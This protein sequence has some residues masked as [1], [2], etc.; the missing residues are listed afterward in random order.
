MRFVWEN[1][2][3]ATLAVCST[4]KNVLIE[5]FFGMKSVYF[6]GNSID[7]VIKWE[8]EIFNSPKHNKFTRCKKK[9]DIY[10]HKH[11][12]LANKQHTLVLWETNNIHQKNVY[13]SLMLTMVLFRILKTLWKFSC[14]SS[15][16]IVSLLLFFFQLEW[17]KHARTHTH[18]QK[19]NKRGPLFNITRILLRLKR[20]FLLEYQ[21]HIIH[22]TTTQTLILHD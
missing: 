18:L 8:G 19:R 10:V 12:N 14:F 13:L 22:N 16:Y 6:H 5:F 17:N 20:V 1:C 3:L 4:S 7:T 15:F 9:L 11:R 21:H 2:C